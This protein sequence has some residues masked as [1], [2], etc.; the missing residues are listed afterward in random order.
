MK[1][2]R[3]GKIN[4]MKWLQEKNICNVLLACLVFVISKHLVTEL[5]H[6]L[7]KAQVHLMYT[8]IKYIDTNE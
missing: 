3:E 1:E 6:K 8:D 5:V 2:G 7:I 4:R